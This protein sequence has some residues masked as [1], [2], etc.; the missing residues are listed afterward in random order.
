VTRIDLTTREWHELIKPV[1]P[2]ASTD[3]DTREL[4]AIRI[5]TAEYGLFAIAT[6]HY[7]LAAERHALKPGIRL[8]DIPEPVHVRS[9]DAAASLRLF[10]YSKDYDPPLRITIDPVPIPVRA[11]G[12]ET[13][14]NRLAITVEADDGTRLVLHDH[15]DP[16]NDPLASWRKLLAAALNREL[17]RDPLTAASAFR[18]TSAYLPRWTHATRKG[19]QLSVFTGSKESDLVLIVVEPHFLGVQKPVVYLESTAK[20]LTESPWRDE[21]N[22]CAPGPGDDE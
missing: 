8:W 5:E 12:H 21:L 19:E 11:A 1:L 18:L 3:A 4:A 9:A 6:D 16:S 17:A 7:T 15:R 14:V 13:S 20:M 10:T 22:E 2:H